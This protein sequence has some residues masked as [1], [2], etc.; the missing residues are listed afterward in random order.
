VYKTLDI[1]KISR[2]IELLCRRIEERFPGS[3][4]QHVATELLSIAEKIV[5]RSEFIIRP[6]ITLRVVVG[7]VIL[8]TFTVLAYGFTQVRITTGTFQLGELVQV[9]DAALN[10]TVLVGA[11]LFFL[12]TVENKIKRK[13]ALDGLHELRSITHVIDMHQLTKDP[14]AIL[15]RQP[16][17]SSPKREMTPFELHRYLDY[18]SELLSLTAKLAAVYGQSIQDREVLAAVGEVESLTTDLSRKIWQKISGL[19]DQ[20]L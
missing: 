15:H 6:Q 3:G 10:A 2:T 14:S 11:A 8:A 5:T 4:L 1:N 18:C 9:M 19:A 16:T 12:I 17:A 7:M 20:A 13:R